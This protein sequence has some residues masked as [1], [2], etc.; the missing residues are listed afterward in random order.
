[1][2]E[3]YVRAE[4]L[5]QMLRCI[6]A[7]RATADECDDKVVDQLQDLLTKDGWDRSVRGLRPA[8]PPE[9]KLYP[10]GKH[11]TP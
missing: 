2:I 6:N 5:G 3:L 7:G 10:S 1:M 11:P 8:L 9:S 4:L